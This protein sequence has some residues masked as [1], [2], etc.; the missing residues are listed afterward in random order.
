MEESLMADVAAVEA[1]EREWSMLQREKDRVLAI[2]EAEDQLV[3]DFL[4]ADGHNMNL[5][6][7]IA[8]L[9]LIRRG[10]GNGGGFGG[11]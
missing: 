2:K 4:E 8:V 6:M 11:N 10:G 3:A 1:K 5:D 9:A 7:L